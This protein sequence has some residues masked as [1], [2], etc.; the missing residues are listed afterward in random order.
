[1]YKCIKQGTKTFY[2]SCVNNLT[3]ENSSKTAFFIVS[4]MSHIFFEKNDSKDKKMLH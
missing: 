1:M 4:L 2:K 3:A